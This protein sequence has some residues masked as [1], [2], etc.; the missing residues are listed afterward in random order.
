MNLDKASKTVRSFLF[1]CYGDGYLGA[2]VSDEGLLLLRHLC[3][4]NPSVIPNESL[5]VEHAST[6]RD[7]I[8]YQPKKI[9]RRTYASK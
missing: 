5:S 6:A 8:V 3:K 4:W 2:R 9:M 1:Q 7:Y